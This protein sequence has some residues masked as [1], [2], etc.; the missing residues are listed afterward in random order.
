MNG[1]KTYVAGAG[2]IATGL[3]IVLAGVAAKDV[4]QIIQGAVVA[5]GGLATVGLGHKAQ[6][7]ADALKEYLKD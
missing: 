4:D 2:V 6:K 5:L 1:W 7:I 3:G